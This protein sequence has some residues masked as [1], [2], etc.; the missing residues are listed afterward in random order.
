MTKKKKKEAEIEAVDQSD[1][2][3]IIAAAKN[4]YL[5]LIDPETVG[6]AK[7]IDTG[8]YL[9]NAQV[10]GSIFGG[11]PGNQI[12]VLAGEKATG[13]TYIL[14]KIIKQFLKNNPTA[15]AVYI[16]TEFATHETDLLERGLNVVGE[17]LVDPKSGQC[18]ILRANTVESV[19]QQIFNMLKVYMAK[20]HRYPLL[21]GIDSAGMLSTEDEMT[22]LVDEENKTD[23][24]NKAKLLKKIF[25][26]LC[27]PLGVAGVP[28]VV[29]NHVAT[30]RQ[31]NPNPKYQRKQQVGGSGPEY[32][33]TTILYFFKSNDKENDEQVGVLIRAKVDKGRKAVSGTETELKLSFKTGLN[34]YYGLLDLAADAG[35]VQRLDN[36]FKVGGFGFQ[37]EKAILRDPK[38]YFTQ[39]FLEQIDVICQ[40]KFKYKNTEEEE[41]LVENAAEA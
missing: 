18:Q 40:E 37:Y 2:G 1:F 27:V 9:L 5:A 22:H 34:R 25:R 21:F 8:S 13:K 32:A 35:L 15:L 11:V 10:S 4:P 28:L 16:E 29:T 39:E 20:K 41:T 26:T 38:K 6:K 19:H 12:T 17:T 24:G 33:A 14:L 31:S 7:P 23:M 30:D 36:K 3:D